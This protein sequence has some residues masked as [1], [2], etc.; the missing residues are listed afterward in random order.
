M[1]FVV[2]L[3]T[4]LARSFVSLHLPRDI[5]RMNADLQLAFELGGE[6]AAVPF[7]VGAKQGFPLSPGLFFF[8]FFMR[9]CLKSLGEALP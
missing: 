3:F 1:L 2:R 8:F 5:E 7:T 9:A 4:A 6:P